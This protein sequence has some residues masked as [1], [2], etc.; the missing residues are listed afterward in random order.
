MGKMNWPDRV[1][2]SFQKGVLDEA[3]SAA[4]RMLWMASQGRAGMRTRYVSSAQP[5]FRHEFGTHSLNA[6]PAAG[7]GGSGASR[8]ADACWLANAGGGRS[9]SRPIHRFGHGGRDASYHN[10]AVWPWLIGA[11]LSGYLRVNNR[12]KESIEQARKWLQPL[13]DQ[14]GTETHCIGQIWEIHEEPPHRP[15]G[16]PA[17]ARASPRSAPCGRI[18]NVTRSRPHISSQLRSRRAIFIPDSSICIFQFA[19]F[20][21]QF[22]LVVFGSFVS[23]LAATPPFPFP[24]N[25]YYRPG[26]YMPVQVTSHNSR[27]TSLTIA[28]RRH[29]ANTNSPLQHRN[30]HDPPAHGSPHWK[31]HMVLGIRR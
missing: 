11:F 23:T 14:M 18:G 17:R 24:L 5:D 30:S 6:L 27:P 12:S 19:F 28:G 7:S 9:R 8:V 25:G 1:A 15:V 20:N 21:F 22:L 4:W 3:P 13:I 31:H 26:R 29:H 10:G 2:E 16:C